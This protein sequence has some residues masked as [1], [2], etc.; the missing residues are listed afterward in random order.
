M[1]NE[2]M[3]SAPAVSRTPILDTYRTATTFMPEEPEVEKYIS[4][5]KKTIFI[6]T[7]ARPDAK[8]VRLI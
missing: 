4:R 1:K 2:R 7:A 5:E 8:I 3:K 6:N